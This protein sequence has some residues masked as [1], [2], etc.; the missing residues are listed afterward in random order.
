MIHSVLP[1]ID[2]FGLPAA[3]HAYRVAYHFFLLRACFVGMEEVTTKWCSWWAC[4][5]LSSHA[6]PHLFPGAAGTLL[7]YPDDV[8]Y[9]GVHRG[10][11]L[12]DFD[13]ALHEHA[14]ESDGS[15]SYDGGYDYAYDG[16]GS[17]R[18]SS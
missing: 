4:S 14:E 16:W 12:G 2:S 1:A 5:G 13:P 8:P 7:G 10:T 6:L 17:D 11:Y 15:D 18:H 3:R 9:H